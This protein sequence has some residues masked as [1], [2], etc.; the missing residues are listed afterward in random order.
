MS[1]YLT[2]LHARA[3]ASTVGVL[4]SHGDRI[5]N[6][7]APARRIRVLKPAFFIDN[8]PAVAGEIV[9]LPSDDCRGLVA[10]RLAEF[11]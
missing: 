5:A 3:A 8:R 6:V 4:P 11:A 7:V 10:R 9:S 2:Q 1:E